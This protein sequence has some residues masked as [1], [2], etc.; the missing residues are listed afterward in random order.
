VR[1][2]QVYLLEYIRRSYRLYRHRR[3]GRHEAADII[4]RHDLSSAAR[5]PYVQQPVEGLHTS[6]STRRSSIH[7]APIEVTPKF[8]SI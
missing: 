8:T 6:P 2:L 7:R 1:L 4:G 5:V 3:L